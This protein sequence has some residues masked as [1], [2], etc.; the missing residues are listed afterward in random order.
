MPLVRILDSSRRTKRVVWAAQKNG[1]I[2]RGQN[3][4]CHLRCRAGWWNRACLKTGTLLVLPSSWRPS[5]LNKSLHAS[6]ATA[7]P[8]KQWP[9]IWRRQATAKLGHV[10]WTHFSPSSQGFETPVQRG[11]RL[12]M[13]EFPLA[14]VELVDFRRRSGWVTQVT[15]GTNAAG[16]AMDFVELADSPGEITSVSTRRH[17]RSHRQGPGRQHADGV[18]HN[19]VGRIDCNAEGQLDMMVCCSLLS[20]GTQPD[21]IEADLARFALHID[22]LKDGLALTRERAQVQTLTEQSNQTKELLSQI[23]DI[24]AVG[25]WSLDVNTA[26]IEVSAGVNAIYG[27][28]PGNLDRPEIG[29]S[30]YVPSDAL[31]VERHVQAIAAG[32]IHQYDLHLHL[33]DAESNRKS[34]R[35]TARRV[36]AKV[37]G[38]LQDLSQLALERCIRDHA[39]D[40]LSAATW[41]LDNRARLVTCNELARQY[42]RRLGLPSEAGLWPAEWCFADRRF[43][44]NLDLKVSRA[45]RGESSELTAPQVGAEQP[46]LLISPITD[47]AHQV[48]GVRVQLQSIPSGLA[49]DDDELVAAM[50]LL[51][52]GL[53]RWAPLSGDVQADKTA[54]ELLGIPAKPVPSSCDSLFAKLGDEARRARDKALAAMYSGRTSHYR[55]QYQVGNGKDFVRDIEEQGMIVGRSAD[56]APASVLSVLRDVTADN[57]D[58]FALKLLEQRFQGAFEHSGIGMAIVGPDGSWVR[59]NPRICEIVGYTEDELMRLTFQD[60]THPDDLENDLSLLNELAA[61]KRPSYQMEK[62]Y[63]HK[64]G[65]LVHILL[66][67]SAVRDDAGAVIHYVSQIID[68][69]PLKHAQAELERLLRVADSQNAWLKQFAHIVS[70][71]LRSHSNGLSG[72]L[73]LLA[74]DVPELEDL[75]AGQLLK[76]SC[77][78]LSETISDLT[79]VVRVHMDDGELQPVPLAE[80]VQRAADSLAGVLKDSVIDIDVDPDIIVCGI[81]AFIDSLCLNM[82]TNAYKYKHRQRALHMQ[83]RAKEQGDRVQ[84]DFI[85]NGQGIPLERVGNRLF[86][87]YQT[88]HEHPDSRGV[89][90]F[91]VKSQVDA[92]GGSITVQSTSGEGTTFRVRLRNARNASLSGTPAVKSSCSS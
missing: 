81:R 24:S 4:G 69:T 5:K 11:M 74:E 41:I 89:G 18:L 22:L 77:E 34:V 26:A 51:G 21:L 15:G 29:I 70:H 91:L 23:E 90:L 46:K 42:F 48:L 40:R 37:V 87:L 84:L 6:P 7:A 54:L 53:V 32:D 88:F 52:M 13:M 3:N 35:T 92:M 27:I 59:V 58:R 64:N 2:R 38:T 57:K 55:C 68:I 62:R 56:R 43:R 76:A 1:P 82:L 75:R 8:G 25:H 9:P 10:A 85:D 31:V 20:D 79:E 80:F 14:S 33:V 12:L 50:R 72:L 45:Y 44:E 65:S 16:A 60:I 78:R 49:H 36:G 83:V 63:F 17:P 30:Y 61:G 86:G 47:T 71:N 73:A 66:S 67:V 28:S 19:V 39:L